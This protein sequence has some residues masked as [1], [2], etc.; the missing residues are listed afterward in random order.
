MSFGS[1]CRTCKKEVKEGYKA[2]ACEQCGDW[3]LTK[4]IGKEVEKVCKTL[5]CENTVCYATGV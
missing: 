1:D 3:H 5:D 2:I 4:C